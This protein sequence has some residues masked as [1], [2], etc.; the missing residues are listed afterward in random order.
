MAKA[1]GGTRKAPQKSFEWS[2][3]DSF[4][5]VLHDAQQIF[6]I[7]ASAGLGNFMQRKPQKVSDA[8]YEKLLKSGD[9]IEVVHGS[10]EKGIDDLLNGKYYINNDLHVSGFGYYFSKD[11]MTGEGYLSKKDGKML[12]ALIKKSD[13]LQQSSITKEEREQGYNRYLG[14]SPTLKNGKPLDSMYKKNFYDTSTIAA[15]KG[16]KAVNSKSFNVVVI[17]RSALVVRKKG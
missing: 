12:T 13:I 17:D 14:S 11:K 3:S 2:H 4:D 16:Y 5:D 8:E 1:S 6:K 9:Y 10:S 15:R 7:E